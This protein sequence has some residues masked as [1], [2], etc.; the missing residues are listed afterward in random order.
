MIGTPPASSDSHLS[1]EGDHRPEGAQYNE[2][3]QRGWQ[4]GWSSSRKTG[5]LDRRPFRSLYT[6]P[7]GL[8]KPATRQAPRAGPD[9][10]SL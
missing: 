1:R 5:M 10:N 6:Q 9:V 7:S 4:S 2:N 8:G 3:A